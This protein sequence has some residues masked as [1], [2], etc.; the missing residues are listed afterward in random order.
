MLTILFLP[1]TPNHSRFLTHDESTAAVRRMRLDA[2]GSSKESKV[3]NETFSWRW[4][5]NINTGIIL[6]LYFRSLDSVNMI[7]GTVSS[8]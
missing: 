6:I 3:E 7:I 5:C 1:H 2:H 4:V 8:A